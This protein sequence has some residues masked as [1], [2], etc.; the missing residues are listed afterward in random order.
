MQFLNLYNQVPHLTQDTTGKVTK[1]K[2]DTTN[3]S[4]EINPFLAG[5]HKA[6]TNRR[7]QR[8][9]LFGNKFV[10]AKIYDIDPGSHSLQ[11]SYLINGRFRILFC[12]LRENPSTI[13]ALVSLVVLISRLPT[14]ELRVATKAYE[15]LRIDYHS[16]MMSKNALGI[17]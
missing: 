1:S 5:D 6:H 9:N 16:V 12:T 7:A 2:L 10:S 11:H 15:R 8:Q 17:C 13:S 4:Q 3:E 14:N